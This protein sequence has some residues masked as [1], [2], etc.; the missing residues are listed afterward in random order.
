MLSRLHASDAW[1]ADKTIM[2]LI[3][4]LMRPDQASIHFKRTRDHL[5]I[6]HE[7]PFKT[8]IAYPNKA[9]LGT[10]PG[11]ETW[12]PRVFLFKENRENNFKKNFFKNFSRSFFVPQSQTHLFEHVTFRV[13]GFLIF[14]FLYFKLRSPLA[15]TY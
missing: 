15:F 6:N 7:S 13:S 1:Q 14:L 9:S 4:C 10:N 5:T 11:P 3:L 8:Q 2:I 12:G